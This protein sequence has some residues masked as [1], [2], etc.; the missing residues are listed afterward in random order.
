MVFEISVEMMALSE[1]A[2]AGLLI[3]KDFAFAIES[4]GTKDVAFFTTKI[5]HFRYGMPMMFFGVPR[6]RIK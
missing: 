5:R 2:F 4:E 3:D 6:C 1:I